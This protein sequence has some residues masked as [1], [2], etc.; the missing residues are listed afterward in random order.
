MRVQNLFLSIHL[1]FL[2]GIDYMLLDLNEI[3]PT[4][5]LEF[6]FIISVESYAE[7]TSENYRNYY[8]AEKRIVSKLSKLSIGS[9]DNTN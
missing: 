1:F 9:F 6:K 5:P 8:V 3:F 7:K 4:K 2:I